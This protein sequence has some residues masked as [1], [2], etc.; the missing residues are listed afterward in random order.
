[1]ILRNLMESILEYW[2][3]K[4]GCKC[5]NKDKHKFISKIDFEGGRETYIELKFLCLQC[6]RAYVSQLTVYE[7]LIKGMAKEWELGD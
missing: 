3:E 5:G 6:E 4:E 2:L 1:M 7:E